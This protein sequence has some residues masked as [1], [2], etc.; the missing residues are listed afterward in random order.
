MP[1]PSRAALRGIPDI[2]I[3]K[4]LNDKVLA[5]VEYFNKTMARRFKWTYRGVALVREKRASF[6]QNGMES[7]RTKPSCF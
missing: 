7:A 5:F 3:T 1:A 6:D 2:N 4:D